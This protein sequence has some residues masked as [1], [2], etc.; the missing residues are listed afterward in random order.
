MSTNAASNPAYLDPIALTQ[1]LVRFDTTNPLGNEVQCIEHIKALLDDAGIQN[2]VLAE[3][4]GLSNPIAQLSGD[5]I[6]GPLLLQGHID[7]VPSNPERW[8]HPPFGGDLVDGFLWGWGSLGMKSGI[9]MMLHA[10]LRA[11]T[12]G[13]T[14]AGDVVLALVSD[15]ESGGD[16]GGR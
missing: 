10:I 16:Q 1:A 11:K 4:P 8:Q 6:A 14:S 12:D 9:A 5:G 2:Q 7:V 3:V 15:E 13:M